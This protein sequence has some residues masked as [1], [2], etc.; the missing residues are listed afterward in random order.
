MRKATVMITIIVKNPSS[1]TGFAALL[2][3]NNW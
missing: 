1:V 3:T 2:A